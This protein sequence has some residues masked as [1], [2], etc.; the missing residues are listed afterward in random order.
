MLH[1]DQANIRSTMLTYSERLKEALGGGTPE[2]VRRLSTHLGISYQAVKQVVDGKTNSFTVA[3]HIRACRFLGVRSEWLGLEEG[4][5]RDEA[6]APAQ[7]AVDWRTLAISIASVHPHA[8]ARE[9]LLD[10]CDR[11][12]AQAEQIRLTATARAKTHTP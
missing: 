7:A 12:D 6:P 9:Q 1:A 4:P 5:M 8:D 3:N 2:Q 11:V 10:F